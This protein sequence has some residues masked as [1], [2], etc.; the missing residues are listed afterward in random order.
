MIMAFEDL[1][2]SNWYTGKWDNERFQLCKK[3]YTEFN[4]YETAFLDPA[5]MKNLDRIEGRKTSEESTRK[6]L[7]KGSK[8]FAV[9]VKGKIAAFTWCEFDVFDYPPKKEFKLKENEAFLF[10]MYTLRAY[11][12]HNLAP[13]VRYR[14][15]EELAKMGRDVLYSY[16]DYFNTP[17]LRFKSKLD[18]KILRLCLNIRLFKRFHW[19]WVLR[20]YSKGHPARS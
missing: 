18:A 9:K 6:L 3:A 19:H 10:D 5:D 11:R 13:F 17:A 2:I 8:C 1:C 4:E 15:Y 7:E 20:N 12:G 14:C 16:S